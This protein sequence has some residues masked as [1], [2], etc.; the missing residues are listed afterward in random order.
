MY[1][2]Y[3]ILWTLALSY[4]NKRIDIDKIYDQITTFLET[5]P[6][7]KEMLDQILINGSMGG[8]Y[9]AIDFY[10]IIS[11]LHIDYPNHITDLRKIGRTFQNKE[12]KSYKIGDMRKLSRIRIR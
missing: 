11:Y 6:K 9:T 7:S 2:Y 1:L 10:Q 12:I 3:L 5:E 4:G 8:F